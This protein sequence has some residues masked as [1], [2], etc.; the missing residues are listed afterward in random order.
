MAER[1]APDSAAS[2][3]LAQAIRP[4]LRVGQ[5]PTIDERPRSAFDVQIK[6]RVEEHARELAEI[7]TRVNGLFFLAISAVL[8]DILLRLAK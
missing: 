7:R 1:H 8:I 4:W 3:R 5:A 6:Q 2:D